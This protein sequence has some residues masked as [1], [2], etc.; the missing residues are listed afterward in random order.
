MQVLPVLPRKGDVGGTFSMIL[1]PIHLVPYLYLV[2][3]DPFPLEGQL[4][5]LVVVR[6]RRLLDVPQE[7]R[8]CVLGEVGPRVPLFEDNYSVF[9]PTPGEEEHTVANLDGQTAA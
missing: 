7:Q 6:R 4:I 8:N 1:N 2:R 5:L 3:V 9:L